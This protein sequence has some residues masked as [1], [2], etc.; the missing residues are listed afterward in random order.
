MIQ[1]I[2]IVIGLL[3]GYAFIINAIKT[4]LYIL[5]IN[6]KLSD[7]HTGEELPDFIFVLWLFIYVCLFFYV[8]LFSDV[9]IN[10]TNPSEKLLW[11][12]TKWSFILIVLLN[13]I[14]SFIKK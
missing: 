4:A 7:R 13:I 12:Y 3:L 10:Y 6:P 8:I 9:K 14:K 1:I 5:N 2:L 11:W